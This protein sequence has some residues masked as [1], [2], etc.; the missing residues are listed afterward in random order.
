MLRTGR[1]SRAFIVAA[2]IL[3][4]LLLASVWGFMGTVKP[5]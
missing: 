5:D 4:L 2:I 3:G 1:Q